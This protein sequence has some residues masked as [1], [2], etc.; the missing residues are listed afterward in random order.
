MRR[1]KGPLWVDAVEEVA[2]LRA[3][4]FSKSGTSLLMMGRWQVERVTVGAG[5]S[6]QFFADAGSSGRRELPERHPMYLSCRL[7]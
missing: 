1:L 2:L 4:L 3:R 6:R 7:R 5:Y